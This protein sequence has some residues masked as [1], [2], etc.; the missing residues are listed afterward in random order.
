MKKRKQKRS[1]LRVR[2]PIIRQ[3]GESHEPK[4]GGKYKR[5]QEKKKIREE[6]ESELE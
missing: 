4:K 1:F 5:N 3:R 6:L 2:L